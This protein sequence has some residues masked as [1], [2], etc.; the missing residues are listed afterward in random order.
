MLYGKKRLTKIGFLKREFWHW[1]T[2]N[3][4]HYL[5]L[6]SIDSSWITTWMLW[7]L[8]NASVYIYTNRFKFP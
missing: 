2:F 1:V 4:H 5:R 3:S 6:K 7:M 8:V